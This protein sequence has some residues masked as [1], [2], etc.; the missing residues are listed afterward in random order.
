MLRE[1]LINI[2]ETSFRE[3]Y[4]LPALTDYFK[5]ENFIIEEWLK[6]NPDH[7]IVRESLE[8]LKASIPEPIAFEDLDFNFGM[9]TSLQHQDLEGRSNYLLHLRL[10]VFVARKINSSIA[11]LIIL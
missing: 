11:C 2:Y 6:E 8:A 1:N 4:A 10:Q 9:L 7:A 5:Q 3:N